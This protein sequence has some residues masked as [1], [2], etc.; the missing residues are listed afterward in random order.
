MNWLENKYINLLSSRLKNFKR[1][2]NS[3]YNFSCPLCGDSET[4]SR[5]ARGYFYSK[6]NKT[7]MHCHN[8]GASLDF[9]KFLSKIDDYL[10][11]QF[12]LEKLKETNTTKIVENNFTKVQKTFVS[13]NDSLVKLKTINQL[14][15]SDEVKQLVLKRK[16]PIKY[17]KQLYKVPKFFSWVNDLVPDK[18]DQTTLKYEE[19]R[20]L[21]PFFNKNGDMLAFQGRSLNSNSKTK[22]ITIILNENEPK[23]FGLDTVNFNKKTYVFEGPIDAM[24]INNAIAT[25]GGDIIS[26]VGGYNKDNFVICYDN[27]PR[28]RETIKKI[29]KAID[30][31]Y[32]VFI[33]PTNI[34]EK[35]INDLVL[36]N[37]DTDY[38]KVL[39]D[40]N[41]Y[42]GLSAKMALNNWKQLYD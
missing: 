23:L 2:S 25:A 42:K 3:L 27:E 31:D 39:I 5:K 14:S 24:F 17:W 26:S 32:S 10:Y 33:W 21:I 38:I 28:G 1:K 7:I 22:Y 9:D 40:K 13:K 29:Q 4:D 30:N 11:K 16:L 41:I 37:F 8:C 35:D 36:K 6:K 18:F 15:D 34:T 12:L 19:T 20:L